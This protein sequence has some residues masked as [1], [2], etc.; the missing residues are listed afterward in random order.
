MGLTIRVSYRGGFRRSFS[1][2][3]RPEYLW[4]QPNLLFSG[5]RGSMSG[6]KYYM[7]SLTERNSGTF[8]KVPIWSCAIIAF[9]VW[10]K[11]NLLQ[12]I[13]LIPYLDCNGS[14]SPDY[15]QKIYLIYFL[16]SLR[17]NRHSAP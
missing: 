1:S 14:K 7:L 3:K 10:Y 4:S 16:Q 2:P 11:P 15:S 17:Y 6:V 12:N 13:I 5:N 8:Q 9:S